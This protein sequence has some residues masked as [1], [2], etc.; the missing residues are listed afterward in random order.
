MANVNPT[1]HDHRA[2]LVPDAG[3]LGVAM[4]ATTQAGVKVGPATMTT[5][6]GSMA[7]ATSGTPDAAWDDEITVITTE[8]G[9]AGTATV[10]H[11]YTANAD[12]HSWD[13]PIAAA[14]FEFIDRTT[15]ADYY[16]RIHAIR[17]PDTGRTM[18][19]VSAT[20]G[21]DT[22]QVW[23]Q[24]AFGLWSSVTVASPGN[25][26]AA[27]LVAIPRGTGWRYLCFYTHQQSATS[28]QIRMSYSDDSGAT[29]TVGSTSCLSTALTQAGS[30]YPRLRAVYLNGAICLVVWRNLTSDYLAQYV[31]T[32]G[33][34]TLDLV[35]TFSSSLRGCHDMVVYG[36]SI[37]IGWIYNESTRTT[38]HTPYVARLSSASQPISSV[39]GAAVNVQPDTG[40]YLSEWGTSAIGVLTA[41][42]FAMV[43]DDDGLIW[44]YGIDFDSTASR[45][46]IIRVSADLGETWADP[47]ISSHVPV[48]VC[49][50]PGGDTSTYPSNLCAVLERGRVTMLHTSVSNPLNDNATLMATYLGGWSTRGMNEDATYSG[51]R[52]YLGVA[53]WDHCYLPL[54]KPGDIAGGYTETIAGTATSSIVN[55]GLQ[56]DQGAAGDSVSYTITP[57]MTGTDEYGIVAEFHVDVASGDWVG[58][59]RISNGAQAFSARATVN[60]TSI[61]VRD[62]YAGANLKTWTTTAGANG[63]VVRISL[64]TT[65]YGGNNGRVTVSYRQ[66]G[67]YVGGVINHGPRA[68]RVWEASYSATGL[69][70]SAVATAAVTWGTAGGTANG[71]A[72][73][74]LVAY[75]D[76]DYTAGNA[77]ATGTYPTRG[78]I[79]PSSIRPLHLA[80]GARIHATGGYSYRGDTW[81]IPAAYEYPVTNLDPSRKPSPRTVWRSSASGTTC[82]LT[83]TV[84]LGWWPGDLL[85]VLILGANWRTGSLYYGSGLTKIMDI[86]LGYTGLGFVRGRDVIVPAPT[87]AGLGWFAHEGALRGATV[88]LGGG[89]LRKVRHNHAG[90]W[91]ASGAATDYPAARVMLEDYDAGDAASGTLDLRMPGGLFIADTLTSTDLLTL[92]IDAQSTAEGYY[93]TGTILIGKVHLLR[94]YARG[95][96]AAWSPSTELVT[97]DNGAR[98]ARTK[99]STRRKVEITWDDPIDMS[100]VSGSV[101]SAPAS[102]S[103][104]TG[105][106]QVAARGA[107]PYTV[108]GL[109]DLVGGPRLPIGYCPAV[110][111]QSG[112]ITAA[113]PI[114]I[115]NPHGYLYGRAMVE[116]WRTDA[117][118]GNEDKTELVRGGLLT[119][120]EEK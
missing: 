29:W 74:R 68:D 16:G 71:R 32:D 5:G 38:D 120:E 92:R 59:V 113:S 119:I 44:C 49:W 104:G 20:A 40:T 50:W 54:D 17:M 100:D 46:S 7:L 72:Y 11:K 85:G 116:E 93:E 60:A 83:W 102:Y 87:G 107:T 64:D 111:I 63:G 15:T 69:T 89:D 10:R 30:A 106:D 118:L 117:Q 25:S 18:A 28:T 66:D 99:G 47:F 56:L 8:A 1:D 53:G 26:T 24:D 45:E 41:A 55:R 94:Q 84:D 51:V 13:P 103:I 35:E 82:D 109:M 86:D 22:V 65:S 95:R 76:G 67:P 52:R 81:T 73:W 43:V 9:T 105:G 42:E 27:C 58:D 77:E 31:S 96:V 80:E 48:G 62:L 33:G 112:A 57:A 2:L 98:F 21:L 61:V 12:Y 101:T 90:A 97:M 36:S 79:L 88:D 3:V 14:G 19:V 75:S 23:L 91:L 34:G 115:L 4:T 39:M 6:S 37:Y 110:P 114:R 108:G 78:R 70:R